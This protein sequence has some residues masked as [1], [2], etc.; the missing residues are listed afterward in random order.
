MAKKLSYQAKEKIVELSGA[1]FWYWNR[2]YSF[3]DSCEVPK[4][5]YNRYPKETYNKYNVMRNVLDVLEAQNHLDIINNIISAFY[6]MTNAIDKDNLDNEK[7]KSLLNEFKTLVGTNPIENEIKIKKE[8]E[9][10]IQKHNELAKKKEI[11][12]SLSTLNKEFLNLF[13]NKTFT[14]QQR[15]FEFEKI[16]SE[17]LRINEFNYSPPYKTDTEQID[18]YFSFEKFDYLVELKWT[19]DSIKQKDLSIFDGKLKGKA[20][21]TRGLFISINGF[22][23]NSIFKFTGDSP[24]IILMDGADLTYI[25]SKRFSFYDALMIKATKLAKYGEIFYSL[26]KEL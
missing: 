13:S 18:G 17:L 26:Q 10:R 3:L 7:A 15:G 2:F 16:F 21:S 24:I 22:D 23:Q 1:C 4:Q 12:D 9:H 20:Q 5:L 11:D 14:P 19:S 25:L 8:Q 6:Q